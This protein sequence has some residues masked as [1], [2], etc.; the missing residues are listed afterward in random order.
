MSTPEQRNKLRLRVREIRK[1]KH[2]FIADFWND[3]DYVGGCMAGG[4][5]YMH[6]T[7][8]GDVEP[9]VFAHFAVD[10]INNKSLKNALN[11]DYFK[12]IRNAFPYN[13][14]KNLLAPCMIIDNP[15]VLR[16]VNKQYGAKSTQPG[17]DA[18]TTDP[19]IV[20]FLDDYSAS[21]KK[22]V[23]PVWNNESEY[24][25]RKEYWFGVNG[26]NNPRPRKGK[27]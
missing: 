19:K 8:M 25:K 16:G 6:I 21:W 3:G 23:D 17:G 12:A 5:V 13:S 10:N 22:I 9:C 20:R 2:I 11:S 1:T 24:Q 7:N 15:Q 14:N 4:R 26:L 27:K 18:I